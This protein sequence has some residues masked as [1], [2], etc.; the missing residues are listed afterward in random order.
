MLFRYY[1]RYS[2]AVLPIDKNRREIAID[3][4]AKFE[5]SQCYDTH[6]PKKHT[7]CLKWVFNL[8]VRRR[9]SWLSCLLPTL[10]GTITSL[11]IL[12]LERW[13][14]G[15]VQSAIYLADP[16]TLL[17]TS[18]LKTILSLLAWLLLLKLFQRIPEEDSAK[19]M[20]G[21]SAHAIKKLI[22]LTAGLAWSPEGYTRTETYHR[23]SKLYHNVW[24]FLCVFIDNNPNDSL[25]D[26]LT[27]LQI[28][29]VTYGH[30]TGVFLIYYRTESSTQ[31]I[32][33]DL[34]VHRWYHSC[35]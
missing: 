13:I 17:G 22:R 11:E 7:T 32:P 16:I 23:V 14:V 9:I 1:I 6:R 28:V 30:M 34:Y 4:E 24:L 15:S 3:A 5:N 26:L 12:Q 27:L 21:K 2:S 18:S 8:V 10:C 19:A 20:T 25:N 29:S 33:V 35:M 31:V